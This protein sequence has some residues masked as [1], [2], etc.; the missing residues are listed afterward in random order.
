MFPPRAQRLSLNARWA[1]SNQLLAAHLH[2][3]STQR[4]ERGTSG[5]ALFI[6]LIHIM[7]A[8]YFLKID[9]FVVT[10]VTLTDKNAK[11]CFKHQEQ[12]FAANAPL[13]L[14]AELFPLQ[15]CVQVGQP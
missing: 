10:C 1:A 11:E 13:K 9:F 4:G 5:Q 2:T 14:L 8:I 12:H 7:G 6:H 3:D 15:L